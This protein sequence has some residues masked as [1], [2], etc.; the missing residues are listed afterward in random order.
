MLQPL[1]FHT[2]NSNYENHN[3]K[4]TLLSFRAYKNTYTC[5]T[6]PPKLVVLPT[7]P[8]ICQKALGHHISPRHQKFWGGRTRQVC[9]W[10]KKGNIAAF[11]GQIHITSIINAFVNQDKHVKMTVIVS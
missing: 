5:N 10:C 11:L 7:Y 2:T 8:D 4:F 6:K 1:I 9:R 3:I